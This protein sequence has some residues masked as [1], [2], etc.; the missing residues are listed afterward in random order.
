MS[1]NWT[2][3]FKTGNNTHPDTLDL[4]RQFHCA[5]C[6]KSFQQSHSNLAAIG[7]NS[8]SSSS[9]NNK[10]NIVRSNSCRARMNTPP[11]PLAPLVDEA[12]NGLY[13]YFGNPN[14]PATFGSEASSDGSIMNPPCTSIISNGA[15]YQL[16]ANGTISNNISSNNVQSSNQSQSSS[17]SNAF[18]S[19]NQ[20]EI[21]ESNC[22]TNDGLINH[23]LNLE[24]KRL[25]NFS[26]FH[27][28]G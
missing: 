8:S 21:S 6:L 25:C 27:S 7:D 2:R 19:P 5:D 1:S 26:F 22:N 16:F 3:I 10:E 28:S 12:M 9:Y 24:E 18:T 14:N 23:Q 4:F 13:H 11:P 15:S 17:S 20:Y